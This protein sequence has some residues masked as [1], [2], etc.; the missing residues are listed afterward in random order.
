MGATVLREQLSAFALKDT[1]NGDEF[2][3]NYSMAPDV[4]VA[5]ERMPGKKKAKE[6]IS[7]LACANGDGSERIPLMIIASAL[8]PRA[9]KKKTGKQWGFDY[10]ANKKA[11][12]A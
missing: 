12:M 9:F 2:G 7:V 10:H 3:L 6:R 5:R 11:W 1:F 8:K 4:I